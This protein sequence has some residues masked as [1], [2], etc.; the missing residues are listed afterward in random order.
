MKAAPVRRP[1]KACGARL[2]FARTPEGELVPLDAQAPTWEIKRDMLGA[3]T[4]V[5]SD[6]LVSHFNVCP[7]A[8]DFSRSARPGGAA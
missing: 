2:I 8:N 5:R 4:A 3:E 7:K 1:C 6:A